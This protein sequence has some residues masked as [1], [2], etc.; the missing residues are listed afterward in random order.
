MD[1]LGIAP[2][3][4]KLVEVER[5]SPERDALVCEVRNQYIFINETVDI[6]SIAN[7]QIGNIDGMRFLGITAYVVFS[8]N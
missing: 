8:G 3:P 5:K 6:H 7:S 2:P 1:C 4:F